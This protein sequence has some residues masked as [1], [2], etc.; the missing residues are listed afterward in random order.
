MSA[1]A[2]L[3]DAGKRLRADIDARAQAHT[4]RRGNRHL[5]I[6]LLRALDAGCDYD[7]RGTDNA[8]ISGWMPIL[9]SAASAWS[10]AAPAGLLQSVDAELLLADRLMLAVFR[11]ALRGAPDESLHAAIR[12]AYSE[13]RAA[14]C[15]TTMHNLFWI[16]RRAVELSPAPEVQ[17]PKSAHAGSADGNASVESCQP[18]DDR[19]TV[20]VARRKDRKSSELVI[21]S[22]RDNGDVEYASLVGRTRVELFLLVAT[23]PN[24]AEATWAN[25]ASTLHATGASS[26]NTESLR[27]LGRDLRHQLPPKLAAR[28]SQSNSGVRLGVELVSGVLDSNEWVLR[29]TD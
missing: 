24:R 2:A 27:R 19:S 28:W 5:R 17:E 26:A 25:L 16:L 8:F 13:L 15:P 4:R 6:Q 18:S 7:G 23:Q 1:E 20:R 29:L 10:E 9:R 12:T 3:R 11:L 22:Y 21:E 14:D